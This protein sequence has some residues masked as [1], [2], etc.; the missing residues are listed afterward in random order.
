MRTPTFTEKEA[1]Q[2]EIVRERF[3]TL[4]RF[5][6]QLKQ[7]LLT[8]VE[9]TIHTACEIPIREAS[10]VP[11]SLEVKRLDST[12]ETTKRALV[13][14]LT[15][16]YKADEQ[17]IVSTKRLSGVVSIDADS[18]QQLKQFN[19]L[20]MSLKEAMLKLPFKIRRHMHKY[21]SSPGQPTVVLLQAY[22]QVPLYSKELLTEQ[23]GVVAKIQ[24]HWRRKGV[25]GKQTTVAE[26]RGRLI[27]EA[28]SLFGEGSCQKPY[29]EFSSDNSRLTHYRMNI[30]ALTELPDN[31]VLF[32]DYRL[33]RPHPRANI[34][35]ADEQGQVLT[36]PLTPVAVMPIFIHQTMPFSIKP[37]SNLTPRDISRDGKQLADV[38]VT[39]NPYAFRYLV[40]RY[41]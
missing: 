34:F 39:E 32:A 14:L 15:D 21:L 40:P 9:F 6:N 11:E 31:E 37:L 24:L 23:P 19:Q 1:L 29:T 18:F 4:E 12:H 35:F 10:E 20:K 16:F 13:N 8:S 38:P 22:R 26:L 25:G 2:R 7:Q 41:S 30:E 27:A 36:N 33:I 3:H 28:N 17:N 5:G